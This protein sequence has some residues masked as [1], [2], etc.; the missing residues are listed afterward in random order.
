MLGLNEEDEEKKTY[1]LHLIFV[2]PYHW[3]R[4]ELK[5]LLTIT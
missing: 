4:N 3:L 2:L 1:K 5:D